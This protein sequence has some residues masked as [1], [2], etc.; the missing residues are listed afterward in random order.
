M[1]EMRMLKWVGHEI[2]RTEEE[3]DAP[4]QDGSVGKKMNMY[5]HIARSTDQMH[6]SESHS[7]R[8]YHACKP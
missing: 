3:K 2:S 4:L 5:N 1:M 7:L 6:F 8:T